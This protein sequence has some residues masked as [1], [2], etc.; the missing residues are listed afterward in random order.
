MKFEVLIGLL[1]GITISLLCCRWWQQ[2]HLKCWYSRIPLIQHPQDQAG[3]GLSNTQYISLS[4]STYTD[5][6][7]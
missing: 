2:V 5:L 4:N 7:S 6:S 3:A 1:I